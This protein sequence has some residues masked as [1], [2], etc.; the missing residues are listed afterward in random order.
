MLNLDYHPTLRNVSSI[1]KRHLPILY[2]SVAMKET[3][4]PDK[5]RIMIGFRRHKNLKEIL[6]PAAFPTNKNK[7]VVLDTGCKN[8]NK[9]CYVCRDFLQ[10][11]STITSL[12]TGIKYKIKE[13]LSCKGDWVVYCGTCLKCRKQDVGSTVTEF[14]TR[15]SNQKSHINT[16]KKNLHS[17]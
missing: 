4:N 8:C 5:T 15:W 9:K 3:F 6:S 16:K 10:E 2:K 7:Q 12:A 1:I 14:Y 11:N 13:S 17:C